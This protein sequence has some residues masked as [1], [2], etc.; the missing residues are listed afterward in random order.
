MAVYTI[1]PFVKP[2]IKQVWQPVECLYTRYNRFDNRLYRVNGAFVIVTQIRRT[3]SVGCAPV[4]GVRHQFALCYEVWPTL[5]VSV[6]G[7]FTVPEM[8]YNVFSGTLNPTHSLWRFYRRLVMVKRRVRCPLQSGRH[9]LDVHCM[10]CGVFSPACNRTVLYTLVLCRAGVRG[11]SHWHALPVQVGRT[12]SW[13]HT[14]QD[15]WTAAYQHVRVWTLLNTQCVQCLTLSTQLN[16]A[17]VSSACLFAT[18][19]G[20]LVW[21]RHS[22]SKPS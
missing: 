1:Q 2:V 22:C 6:F 8:T 11:V 17:A 12:W 16:T 4:K 10:Y 20:Q 9:L 3:V 13:N 19:V 15:A 5:T 18:V 21:L 14:G 7:G